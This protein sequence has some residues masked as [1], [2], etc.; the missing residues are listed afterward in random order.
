MTSIY[1]SGGCWPTRDQTLLLRAALLDAPAAIEAWEEW[2]RR[3]DLDYLEAG[4]FRLIGLLYRNLVRVGANASDPLLPRLKG[5]YRHFWAKNHLTMA[6]K[7]GLLRALEDKG[8]PCILLKGAALTLTVYHD[9]GVRPMDDLDVMVPPARTHEAM[10]VLEALGWKAEVHSPRELPISIHA[11]SFRNAAGDCVDLHWRLCHLPASTEFDRTLWERRLP[12]EFQGHQVS[13]P[14]FT[15]QLL[16]TCAHGPQYK[17]ASPVRWI[18]DAFWLLKRGGEELDWD[19]IARNAPSVGAVLGVQGTLKYLREELQ[20]L[21]PDRGLEITSK[22]VA[23]LQERWEARLL[24]KNLP[25]PWHRM[26]V[27]FSHHLRC[28]RGQPWWNRVRGFRV[29]FR[30]AN[31]LAPGQFSAHQKAR[32]RFWVR[33]WLPWYL[34]HFPLLFLRS[35]DGAVHKL[36]KDAFGGFHE[37][38]P[39]EH[40]LVRWSS[41]QASLRLGFA[42]GRESKVEIDIGGMRGW[43][44]DLSNHLRFHMDGRPVPAN[45][46]KARRGVLTVYPPGTAGELPGEGRQMRT[47]SWSCHPAAVA[48]DPRALGLPVFAVRVCTLSAADVARVQDRMDSASGQDPGN[49]AATKM[50]ASDWARGRVAEHSSREG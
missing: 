2:K 19:R 33:R 29:Y 26:P 10:D 1:A 34:C 14:C 38:E 20:V 5:I 3:N 36:P 9:H 48:G 41:T 47:L 13:V 25:T 42:P 31:N 17:L 37:L 30:H 35:Q 6:L 40:R 15:D 8:I 12:L 24:S 46:V 18:A 49:T 45:C 16:H 11:C 39:F 4:T 32:V 23:T 50:D 44:K 28:S 7:E 27:D 43:K 22:V 21:V